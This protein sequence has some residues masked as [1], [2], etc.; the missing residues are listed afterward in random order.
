MIEDIKKYLKED[1]FFG[2]SSVYEINDSNYEYIW[3]GCLL[4][5]KT[6]IIDR[7]I[8]QKQTKVTDVRY[9]SCVFGGLESWAVFM[10]DDRFI[11]YITKDYKFQASMSP[12]GSYWLNG[13]IVSYNIIK[14]REETRKRNEEENNAWFYD[15]LKGDRQ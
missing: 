5:K 12:N 1:D 14:E 6:G 13:L 10:D 9:E 2:L 3:G 8:N 11:G 4:N 15:F 7:Y